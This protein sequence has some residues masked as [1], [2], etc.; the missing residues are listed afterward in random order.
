MTKKLLLLSLLLFSIFGCNN[1]ALKPDDFSKEA[2]NKKYPYWQVGVSR[3]EISASEK[4]YTTIT[5]QEK[6]FILLCMAYMRLA[7]NT[8]EFVEGVYKYK[9][10]LKS[11]ITDQFEASHYK[12]RAD[13]LY[14]PDRLIEI[15]RNLKYDFL[16]RKS[17]DNPGGASG[18]SGDSRYVRYGYTKIF[19]GDFV[20]FVNKNWIEWSRNN[21]E[22]F[23]STAAL[24]FHEHMHNIGFQHFGNNKV[25]YVLQ[26]DIL[27]PLLKRILTGD[28]KNKYAK[29]L[30]ELTAYYYNEYKH[31]LME[32]SVFDPNIK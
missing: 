32:D 2:I 9:N 30:E 19:T 16:Y 5:V 15:I 29:Q 25:P 13:E 28:L 20:Q 7:V 14:D 23:A 3:F 4:I 11:S 12:I 17:N 26:L 8:P 22:G 21:L 31:L 10:E 18:Q 27:Y 24:L 1:S 6:R